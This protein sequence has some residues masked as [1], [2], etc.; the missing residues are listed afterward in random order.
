MPVAAV[1]AHLSL[2]NA[3][4]TSTRIAR[5]G[6]QRLEARTAIRPSSS[7]D[8]ALTAEVGLT[9]ETLEVTHV[10][11]LALRLRAL[12]SEDYLQ[13][14]THSNDNRLVVV[15]VVVGNSSFPRIK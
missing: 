6:V 14:H 3:Y 8:V 10:P 15:V 11:T 9:L 2:V 4:R 13:Q 7:H 12:V 5:L 1:M